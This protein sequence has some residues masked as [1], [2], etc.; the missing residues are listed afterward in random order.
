MSKSSLVYCI[1]PSQYEIFDERI[2]KPVWYRKIENGKETGSLVSQEI[3]EIEFPKNPFE[4]FAPN[5][6]G[7]LLSISQR[8]KVLAKGLYDEKINP[9]NVKHSYVET[10]KDKKKFLQEKSIVSAD[11]IELIQIS[12]VF[13][14]T[15]IESFA[16]L[17][18]PEDYEYKV[19]VKSK[20]ITE[21]YDKTAIER[22]VSLTDKIAKVL[23]DVYSTSKIES[24]KFWS[25]LKSLEKNRHNIIHQKSINRTE[26]YK[27]YFKEGIFKQIDSAQTVLQ[28]FYDAHSKEN[29]TNPLW[30]WAIGKEKAFPIAE[31]ES[32]NFEVVGNL[33]E[34]KM[35]I[36]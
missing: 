30:P 26:F 9:N 23:T 13:A 22:W 12:V 4:F 31:F 28:F 35:K 36:K 19:K 24:Q 5:N 21:I 14:Y 25:N 7:M 15:A 29:R 17:S 10:E 20:G 33:F 34:G 32:K 18:I 11:Y 1:N 27:E 3:D 16:N 2:N 8:Y 6:V